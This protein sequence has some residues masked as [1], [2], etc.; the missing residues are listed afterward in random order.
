ML[1][2]T[3]I[4]SGSVCTTQ[5]LNKDPPMRAI[6]YAFILLLSLM[7]IGCN[8]SGAIT[9]SVPLEAVH[10]TMRDA[11]RLIR[12]KRLR[13]AN[14]VRFYEAH[15]ADAPVQVEL[16]IPRDELGCGHWSQLDMSFNSEPCALLLS[17]PPPI[18]TRSDGREYL[19]CR[20]TVQVMGR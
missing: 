19:T 20:Y 9:L 8:K 7:T 14:G 4:H 13:E 15:N 18:T 11:H 12:I 5:L 6:A 3:P 10:V 16:E 17:N 2:W 1:Y